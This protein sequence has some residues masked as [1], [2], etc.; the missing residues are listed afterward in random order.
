MEVYLIRRQTSL[1]FLGG[2][3]AF[4]GGALEPEDYDSENQALVLD[5]PPETAARMLG[6]NPEPRVALAYW[7]AGI[8]E[9][10]EETGVLLARPAEG[11]TPPA[12]RF[13]DYQEK[14]RENSLPF[15]EMMKKE[16]LRYDA[17]ALVYFDHWITPEF[18]P[19]RYDVRFFFATVPPGQSPLPCPVEFEAADWIWPPEALERYERGDIRMVPPTRWSLERLAAANTIE[20]LLSDAFRQSRP[21]PKSG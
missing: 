20:D 17:A 16:N 8:R 18:S 21:P 2:F 11:S 9:L 12:V 15:Q 10:F 4:P 3:S 1:S 7:L 19:I 13:S 6:G 14:I 5:F